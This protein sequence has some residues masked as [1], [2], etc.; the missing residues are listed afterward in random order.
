MLLLLADGSKCAGPASRR[1]HANAG[2]ALQPLSEPV[3]QGCELRPELLW[4]GPPAIRF[5]QLDSRASDPTTIDQSGDW[6]ARHDHRGERPPS[7]GAYCG[8]PEHRWLLPDPGTW[9]RPRSW[10]SAG[11]DWTGGRYRRTGAANTLAKQGQLHHPPLRDLN[12]LMGLASSYAQSHQRCLQNR[13]SLL[14]E[15]QRRRP[16]VDGALA[17][18][19]GLHLLDLLRLHPAHVERVRHDPRAVLHLLELR[20]QLHI[21][22]GQEV[23][24]DHVGLREVEREDVLL[25]DLD[26]VP[27]LARLDILL[28]L[29]DALRVNVEAGRLA[30]KFLGGS[31]HD[32]AIA[33]AEVVDDILLLHF[34][35]LQHLVDHFVRRGHEDH[36]R[37]ARLLGR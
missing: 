33:A 8:V 18:V 13:S 1:W 6:T 14:L 10:S 36:I 35:Q 16:Q 31:H 24:S 32:A 23:E 27:H 12:P 25:L 9:R 30:A 21:E 26:E 19:L 29:L 17:V 5:P 20:D 22:F 11:R 4:A 28:R 7:D 15:L 34:R 3:P 2:R 37:P